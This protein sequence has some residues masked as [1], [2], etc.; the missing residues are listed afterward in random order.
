M[1]NIEANI[2]LLG[3]HIDTD[4]IL[5]ARY[6]SKVKPSDYAHYIFEGL[7]RNFANSVSNGCC[8]VVAGENFGYGSSR[9]H[10]VLGLKEA[11]VRAIIATSIA[12]TFFRNAINNG[13]PVLEAEGIHSS[14][15]HG[16]IVKI[17]WDAGKIIVVDTNATYHFNPLGDIAHKILSEG[18][19]IPYLKHNNN[20]KFEF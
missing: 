9:E 14:V 20:F 12:R 16:Q 15:K 18:G 8:V 6:L 1:Q 19:L 2:F 3:D 4:L 7:D 13:L 11:G 10:V 17:D 5:P